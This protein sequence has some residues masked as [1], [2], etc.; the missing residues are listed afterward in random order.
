VCIKRTPKFSFG[1]EHAG[2]GSG[3]EVSF[4]V[5]VLTKT[6]ELVS[7]PDLLSGRWC[8]RRSSVQT[9]GTSGE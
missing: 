1:S 9:F 5:E 4:P 8:R 2:S 6:I 3:F 7:L